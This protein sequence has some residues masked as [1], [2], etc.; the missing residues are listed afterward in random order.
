VSSFAISGASWTLGFVKVVLSSDKWREKERESLEL[1]GSNCLYH[2]R[3]PK[4]RA[5]FSLRV[6]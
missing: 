6:R 1:G 5:S 4:E 2:E 3:H